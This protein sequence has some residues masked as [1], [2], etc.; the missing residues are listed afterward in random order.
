[1]M[2][3]G[4]AQPLP[5]GQHEELTGTLLRIYRDDVDSGVHSAA[6][7]A[8]RRFGSAREVEDATA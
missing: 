1:M 5:T 7:W 4:S 6:E 2:G 8:L 3:L